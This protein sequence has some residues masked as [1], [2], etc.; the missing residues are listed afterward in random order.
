[1]LKR[2]TEG[3]ECIPRR[4]RGKREGVIWYEKVRKSSK[5]FYFIKIVSFGDK[6]TY[7]GETI[8][9]GSCCWVQKKKNSCDFLQ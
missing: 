5:L 3:W 9:I 1:M 2:L 6:K 4:V 8:E 7:K